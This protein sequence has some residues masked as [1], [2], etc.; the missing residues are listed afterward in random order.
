[1][2]RR[3]WIFAAIFVWLSPALSSAE[4]RYVRAG[5]DLQAAIDQAQPGDEL[6]LAARAT[7]SGNFVLPVKTGDATITIRTD[8]PDGGLPT[9]RQRVTPA[10][11]APFAKIVSPNTGA[12]LR[13]APGAHHWRLLF[14][15]FPST[16]EGY[17]DILQLG[18]GSKA[19]N[20]LAQVPYNLELDRVYIHGDALHGQK[21]GVALNARAVTIRNS[22]IGDIK[23]IGIDTQ[24]IGGWNGPGPFT[25]ENNYLEATG[26]NVLIG[27]A[28]PGIPNLVSEDVVVRYNHFTRPMSW[29]DAV[30]PAPSNVVA[31]GTG[32]GSLPAGVYAYQVVAHRPA[33]QGSVAN[34]LPSTE[35]TAVASSGAV[36]VTWSAV[37]G[38]TEYHVYA[39]TP[40]GTTSS[41][42][43][44]APAFVHTSTIGGRAGAPPSTATMW[45]VKNLFELKNARRV[46]V[47]YN[48]FENNW[49]SAQ[50]GYA[51]L[52]TVRNQGG[53][54]TWCVVEH[55]TFSHNVI[56]NVAGGFNI[57]GYDSEGSSQ[58]SNTITITDNF[59]SGMTTKLG[60]TAW[61]FLVGE[62]VR[63]LTIDRNT[64]D[65][66]GTTV[67]YAYGG[68]AAAPKPMHGFTF[69]NNAARHGEYGINGASASTGTLTFQMYFPS[70][71]FTGNWLSGGS[72]ARYPPGNTFQEPFDTKATLSVGQTNDGPGANAAWLLRLMDSV[73]RGV[74]PI[75]P[76]PPTRVRVIS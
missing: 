74:V 31:T 32:T 49:Q 34:S 9:A 27:G 25:I 44:T 56:R 53:Q 66:D 47:E 72:S 3:S 39:R 65:S 69:T 61:G 26:E 67:L 17:G 35:V 15:E 54:C 2:A 19:Q 55:V 41:W 71:T 8:L 64:I 36:T 57:T 16:K 73:L 33:G 1:M 58:Q 10:I 46:R 30:V 60:G 14:L 59:L 21:R 50:T 51:I 40:A 4:V 42:T 20:D 76:G 6:R 28:D 62:A 22:H 18:D 24:A 23:A 75:P 45:Q 43:V 38:A 68:T 13:T 37:P 70:V 11:A 12:S 52:F 5:D 7:F 63:D 29:R 48:L